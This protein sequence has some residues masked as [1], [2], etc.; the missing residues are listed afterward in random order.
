MSTQKKI[1]Q[2]LGIPYGALISVI[3]GLM[4]LS[5]PIGAYLVFNS[6]I[7]DDINYEYPMEKFGF[8]LAGIGFDAPI[9]FELGDGF[10]FLWCIFLILFAVAI[11][12]PKKNFLNSLQSIITKGEYQI[13]DNYMI[14][15]IK[16]FSILVVVS[17]VII[18][19]QEFAGIPLEQPEAPNYLLQF[20]NVTLAP[21]TEEFG[22]RVLLIGL[23]LFALYSHK[24][25][26]GLFIKSLWRP[27][28]NLHI[29]DSKKAL[30]V[31]IGVG[32]LFG[33]AHVISGEA[34]DATK[35]AQATAGGIIL[36]W[37][38][39]RYGIVPA[40]LIHW[41][42]N[43]FIFSYGYI[44]AEINQI[45]IE[46][47]FLDT[48]MNTIEFILVIAGIISVAVFV[49]RYAYLKKQMLKN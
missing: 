30:M 36:G 20:F 48:L 46:S 25:S 1:L 44:I 24:S 18:T 35:F 45:S 49:L 12:G 47:A 32:I 15:I 10:I 26:F 23:P 16:W 13:Q 31:I 6:E 34:W 43:Y 29:F 17:G 9:Q 19:V 40:I 27:W 38:Y 42:T 8:F 21:I 41:A 39:C 28:Y 2:L 33:V 14:A 22:F 4:V 3:F 37:V 5:F 11:L 7:G